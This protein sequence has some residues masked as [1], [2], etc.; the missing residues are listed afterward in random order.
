MSMSV[1]YRKIEQVTQ[2]MGFVEAMSNPEALKAMVADLKASADEVKEKLGVYDSLQKVKA[3]ED[4]VAKQY[5]QMV[6]AFNEQSTKR[7]AAI[8]SAEAALKARQEQHAAAEVRAAVDAKAVREKQVELAEREKTIA[9][10]EQNTRAT[11]AAV[12]VKAKELSEL[13]TKLSDKAAKLQK[14]LGE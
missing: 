1:D 11:W 8:A 2:F 6:K 14:L 3:L 13:E 4:E 7:E 9:S 12:D 10:V 5:D